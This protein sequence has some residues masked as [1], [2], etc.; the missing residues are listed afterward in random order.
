MWNIYGKNKWDARKGKL[1]L[2]GIKK[3]GEILKSKTKGNR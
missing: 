2:D 3:R 1:R